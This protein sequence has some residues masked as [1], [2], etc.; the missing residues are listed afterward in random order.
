MRRLASAARAAS[1]GSG[2]APTSPSRATSAPAQTASSRANRPSFPAHTTVTCSSP[3][4]AS[5]TAPRFRKA[6]MSTRRLRSPFDSPDFGSGSPATDSSA[7]VPFVVVMTRALPAT[8]SSLNSCG[9]LPR[10]NPS[11][12]SPFRSPH[13]STSSRPRFWASRA[14]SS[15]VCTGKTERAPF[16]SAVTTV[17]V[18][19]ITSTTTKVPRPE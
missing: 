7:A 17:L 15:A 9:E 8:R 6:P 10:S 16:S 3:A 4:T 11:M 2:S 5:A 13:S 1:F 19:R 18:A 14:A 12:G